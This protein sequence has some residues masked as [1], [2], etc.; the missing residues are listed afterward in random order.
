MEKKGKDMIDFVKK[1]NL[2]GLDQKIHVKG[3]NE[4]NP[5]LLFLH[6]GPG[7]TNRHSVMAMN[8][9]LL[10]DFTIVAWDQRGTAGSYKGAKEEDLTLNQITEDANALVNYLC[11]KFGKKKIFVIGGSWGSLL[12]TDLLKKHPEKIAAFIGFGQVVNG[13]LNELISWQYCVD[14]ATKAQDQKSLDI[15]NRIGPPEMGVYKG[16]Y[17]GMRAQRDIMMQYGGY[18]KNEKKRNYWDAFVKPIFLSGEYSFSDLVG[19]VK[20]YKFVLKKM[21]PE[22]GA[23]DFA[24]THTKFEAPIFILDGRLDKNTPADLV[25]DWFN[26]IEAP[27]KELHWFENSGHNPMFDEEKK[28]KDLMRALLLPIAKEEQL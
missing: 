3:N 22:V 15:L 24:K 27:R 7:M 19:Y 21:W 25:E 17:S 16:G 10:D 2:N 14:E 28:F 1:V 4:N 12:G 26:L 20:G 6:G 11:E 8:D 23:I 5:V 9:D 18:S 13:H